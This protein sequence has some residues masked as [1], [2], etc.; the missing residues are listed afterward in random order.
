MATMEVAI[1]GVEKRLWSGEA[2][3]VSARTVDGDIGLLP[4]HQPMI[5]ALDEAGVVRIDPSE[6]ESFH[7]AVFGGFLSVTAESVTIL[8]ELAEMAEEVDVAAARDELQR[9]EGGGDDFDDAAAAAARARARLRAA[10][11]SPDR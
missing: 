3:F 4:G 9:A 8:A 6:G 7:A 5:A 2:S 1:V 11:E 10:G